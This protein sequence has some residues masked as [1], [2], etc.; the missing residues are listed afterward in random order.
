MT[1]PLPATIGP[2]RILGEIGAGGMGTVYLGLHTDDDRQAAV[3]VLPPQMSREQGLVLRFNREIDALRKL[4]SPHIV[5][6][7]ESGVDQGVYFY[8]ME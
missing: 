4:D 2:Y 5:Q 1:D 7:F 3:K 6:L 8:A